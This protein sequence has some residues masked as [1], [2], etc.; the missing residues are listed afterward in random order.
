MEVYKNDS[1]IEHWLEAM[2]KYELTTLADQM[3]DR[4]TEEDRL[5]LMH[6]YHPT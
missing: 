4:D 2:T 6:S 1:E 5:K 3:M